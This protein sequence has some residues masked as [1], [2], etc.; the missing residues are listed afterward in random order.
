[1]KR[2]WNLRKI[3]IVLSMSDSPFS[4]FASD[5]LIWDCICGA[6]LHHSGKIKFRGYPPTIEQ[7][8]AKLEAVVFG[9]AALRE[10]DGGHG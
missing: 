7:R 8:L 5:S 6:D 2:R 4:L 9:R 3:W 1:M 10:K